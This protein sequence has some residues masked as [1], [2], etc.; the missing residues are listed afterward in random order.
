MVTAPDADEVEIL[1]TEFQNEIQKLG[2]A[3]IEATMT[4]QYQD[5]LAR[6][7]AAGFFTE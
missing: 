7:Q 5:A 3:D 1:W 2:L 6:Y 4:A